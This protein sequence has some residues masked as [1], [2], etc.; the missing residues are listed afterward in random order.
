LGRRKERRCRGRNTVATSELL[1]CSETRERTEQLLS[2]Q[3]L[4]INEEVA[5]K[6]TVNCTSDAQLTNIGQFLYK[7]RNKW[8][9]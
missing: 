3:W 6:R 9:N 2:R 4:I 7:I 5:F 1:K 8:E